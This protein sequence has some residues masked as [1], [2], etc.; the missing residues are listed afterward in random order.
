MHRQYADESAASDCIVPESPLQ[1]LTKELRL[2]GD[3]GMQGALLLAGRGGGSLR[4]KR[5]GSG[6]VTDYCS[7]L[8]RH[9]FLLHANLH[10][11]P[12]ALGG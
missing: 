10:Y 9:Y 5:L 11:V 6:R 7:G 1:H 8:A 3:K 2:V 4:G 12:A